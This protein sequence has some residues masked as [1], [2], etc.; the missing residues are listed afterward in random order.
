MRNR[1]KNSQ[2]EKFAKYNFFSYKGFSK[3]VN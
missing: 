2:K 1:K 3:V